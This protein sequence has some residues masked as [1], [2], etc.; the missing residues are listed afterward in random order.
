MSEYLS[1][2][3]ENDDMENCDFCGKYV[4]ERSLHVTIETNRLICP[5]C[6]IDTEETE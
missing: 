5:S 1:N 4:D 3:I 2:I 6:A